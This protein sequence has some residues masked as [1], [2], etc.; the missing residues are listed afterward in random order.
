MT[1]VECPYK[2]VCTSYPHKCSRCKHNKYNRRRDYFE[3][4]EKEPWTKFPPRWE[5]FVQ[6]GVVPASTLTRLRE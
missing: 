6:M 5:W 4:V 2:D 1:L 3:P